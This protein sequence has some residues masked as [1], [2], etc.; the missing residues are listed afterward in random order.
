MQK[1]QESG[2]LREYMIFQKTRT[3]NLLDVRTLNMWGHDLVDISIVRRLENVETVS[4]P[5]NKIR[6]LEP[7]ASCRNL[8]N[9]FLR[10][11]LI[12]DPDELSY[13]TDLPYLK[14]LTLSDNPIT[15]IPGYRNCVIR[16][17]PNLEK[18]DDIEVSERDRYSPS[19][20]SDY[21][22]G[23]H[24]PREPSPPMSNANPSK[25][26]QLLRRSDISLLMNKPQQIDEDSDYEFS[27]L[28]PIN[29][30]LNTSRSE[31]PPIRHHQPRIESSRVD[32]SNVLSAVLSLIPELTVESL[33]TVLE[34]IQSRC[35]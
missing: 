15:Q 27:K 2:V 5:I 8:R 7:F 19:Q 26:K 18:L 9:L 6:T 17:L 34:A 33:Q 12:S 32:D 22:Y 13:L 16:I 28:P 30:P 11:N 24:P 31:I 21:G 3:T 29:P 4:L 23:N 20:P 25:R 1:P 35:A 10:Q 14:N